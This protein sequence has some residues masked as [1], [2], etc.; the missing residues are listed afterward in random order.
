[1]ISNPASSG[2]GTQR[3]V[4]VRRCSGTY[5][6]KKPSGLKAGEIL[7]FPNSFF[8][9]TKYWYDEGGIMP[10]PPYCPSC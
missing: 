7:A 3:N 8:N 1:M 5:G 9:D 4:L 2:A 10:V 6:T